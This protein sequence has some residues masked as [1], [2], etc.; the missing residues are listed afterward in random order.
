MHKP[1]EPKRFDDKVKILAICMAG[2]IL[3]LAILNFIK[4]IL[5][6]LPTILVA[7]IVILYIVAMIGMIFTEGEETKEKDESEDDGD[8]LPFIPYVPLP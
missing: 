5:E 6:H 7:S 3:G 4:F 1:L 8:M 2:I